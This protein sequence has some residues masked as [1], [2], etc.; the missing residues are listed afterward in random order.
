MKSA[1]VRL[2]LYFLV[3][4]SGEIGRGEIEMS[5]FLNTRTF[6]PGS[7]IVAVCGVS[8]ST[9]VFGENGTHLG[10]NVPR[11]SLAF[12]KLRLLVI[13]FINPGLHSGLGRSISFSNTTRHLSINELA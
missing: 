12:R 8:F 2:A 1:N 9:R 13:C 11:G 6:R 3:S 10:W 5:L 7:A 4:N